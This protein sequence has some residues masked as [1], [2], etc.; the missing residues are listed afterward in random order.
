[1][2]YGYK[3]ILKLIEDKATNAMLLS[4]RYKGCIQDY[5]EGI[6]SRGKV[7]LTSIGKQM[8]LQYGEDPVIH[9]GESFVSVKHL[10]YGIMI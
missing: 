7:T 1:M 8:L 3:Q 6:N 10:I 4:L 5:N 2:E 9:Y